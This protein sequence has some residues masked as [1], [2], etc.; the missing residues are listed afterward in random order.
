MSESEVSED[1]VEAYRAAIYRVC[2]G[3][4]DFSL[5][6]GERSEPL[7]RVMADTGAHS[8]AFVTAYNP[9]GEL[10]DDTANRAAHERLWHALSRQTSLILDASGTDPTGQWPPEPGY[11]ALGVD[12]QAVKTLAREFGQNAIVWVEA[13]AVPGLILLR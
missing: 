12:Q 7:A 4:G 10:R 5:H 3:G 1:L 13:D 8:A 2:H 6:V 9:H 11:L